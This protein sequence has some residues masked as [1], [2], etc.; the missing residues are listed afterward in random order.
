MDHAGNEK[1]ERFGANSKIVCVGQ[2][3]RVSL[4]N[5]TGP[6]GFPQ[7]SATATGGRASGHPAQLRVCRKMLRRIARRCTNWRRKMPTPGRRMRRAFRHVAHA[8]SA[9]SGFPGAMTPGQSP[10]GS[11][12]TLSGKR[13]ARSRPRH[14][15]SQQSVPAHDSPHWIMDNHKIVIVPFQARVVPD[16]SSGKVDSVRFPKRAQR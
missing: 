16:L 10:A 2:S 12:G 4:A 3:R 1:S 13:I 11:L 8:R 14:R 6:V 5:A 7:Q 9:G 15:S